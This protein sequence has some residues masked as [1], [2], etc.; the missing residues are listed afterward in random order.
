VTRNGDTVDVSYPDDAAGK[1][2]GIYGFSEF[3]D[4]L[5]TTI[6]KLLVTNRSTENIDLI[7]PDSISRFTDLEYLM[8]T[9]CVKKLSDKVGELKKLKF[10]G[11]TKNQNL[12]SL[13]ECLV[14]LVGNDLSFINL[15]GS[16]PKMLIPKSLSEKMDDNEPGFYFL[17]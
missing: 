3:F 2:I 7:I 11:L 17:D 5:P 8:F 1:F 14:D 10:I 13:P 16:N 15:Q 4:S 6:K 9:N 12:V